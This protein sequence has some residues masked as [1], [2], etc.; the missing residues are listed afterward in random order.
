MKGDQLGR[1][2]HKLMH[3]TDLSV[4]TTNLT[5]FTATMTNSINLVTK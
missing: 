3:L 1:L 4:N 2:G 5:D